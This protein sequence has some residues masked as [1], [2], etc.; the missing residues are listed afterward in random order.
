MTP[1]HFTLNHEQAI[2]ATRF[3]ATRVLRK[4]LVRIALLLV[5][6]SALIAGIISIIN[7]YRPPVFIEN[8]L[9][10]FAGYLLLLI[11]LMPAIGYILIPRRVRKSFRQMPALGRE[12]RILWDDT[13]LTITSDY[14]ESN[15]AF[16]EIHQWAAN[17]D[18]LLIYP[19]DHMHHILP[20]TIFG[21]AAFYN[22]ICSKLEKYGSTR[23]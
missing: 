12:Q 23:I 11:L 5:I 7:G 18:F 17:D 9:S 3:G 14:G 1:I 20:R 19:M 2:K 10:L 13:I 4:N 22:E 8:F 16:A 21:S 15:M 6:V